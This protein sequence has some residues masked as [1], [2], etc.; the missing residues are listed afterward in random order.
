MIADPIRLLL[1]DQSVDEDDVLVVDIT[2][3]DPDGD[4]VS[5]S[6]VGIP[7]FA[8]FVDNGNDSAT[9]TVIPGFDDNGSY[10]IT[11]TIEDGGP[12]SDFEL[13]TLYVGHVN[14]PP[15]KPINIKPINGSLINSLNPILKV[16]VFDID[17]NLMNVSFYNA[18]DDNLIGF[19]SNISSNQNASITWSNRNY[20]KTYNWYAIVN[21]SMNQ[22]MSDI[23]SFTTKD[24]PKGSGEKPIA[25]ASKSQTVGFIEEMISFDGSESEDI[26]GIIVNYTWDFDDNGTMGYGKKVT[27][28]FS[29]PGTYNVVLKVKDNSGYTDKD[30]IIVVI[31][32]GNN[33]PSKPSLDGPSKGHMNTSYEFTS[34]SFDLD[35]NTLQYIFDWGDGTDTTTS[36]LPNGTISNQSHEWTHYGVYTITVKAFDGSTESASNSYDIWI[37]V[38]PIDDDIKGQ[39]VDKNSN[40]PYDLFEQDDNGTIINIEMDGDTY[41]IDIDE[42]GKIDYAFNFED[43]LLPYPDYVYN[44]Y[45]EIFNEEILKTP[46]FEMIS[47]LAM[48]GIVLIILRRR[49]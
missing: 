20:G 6:A 32:L 40:E 35:N 49:R 27:H 48:M 16:N 37:D 39:L 8:I 47:L 17:E 15:N 26:D 4:D 13:F 29:A 44:K 9:L 23:W 30:T 2:G 14:R 12:L 33:P 18:K 19:N 45:R 38:Y 43:G 46:G 7:S 11:V 3:S 36:F 31:V 22:T 10:P 28:N 41:L 42:D 34:L 21:D 25:N 24:K 1:L 5:F